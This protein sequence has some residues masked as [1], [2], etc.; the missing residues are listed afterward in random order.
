MNVAMYVIINFLYLSAVFV[1]FTVHKYAKPRIPR[2]GINGDT[3]VPY[4][5]VYIRII[6]SSIISISQYQS[7]TQKILTHQQY[8]VIWPRMW[9]TTIIVYALLASTSLIILF[10]I[11]CYSFIFCFVWNYALTSRLHNGKI[12]I[13]NSIQFFIIKQLKV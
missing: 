1:H 3:C 12:L 8:Y 7:L 11:A 6:S 10:S 13:L 9:Y 4:M 2:L 5:L